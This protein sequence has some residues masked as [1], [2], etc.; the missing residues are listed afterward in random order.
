MKTQ[1]CCRSEIPCLSENT[2]L[3]K[4]QILRVCKKKKKKLKTKHPVSVVLLKC[5]SPTAE[6]SI[7]TTTRCRSIRLKSIMW[8]TDEM[9]M[10]V[11]VSSAWPVCAEETTHSSS[12]EGYV[13]ISNAAVDRKCQVAALFVLP[14]H[15]PLAEISLSDMSDVHHHCFRLSDRR[16]EK[17][18]KARIDWFQL[19]GEFPQ[20]LFE[21]HSHFSSLSNSSSWLIISDLI[22]L[23]D[24]FSSGP[25]TLIPFLIWKIVKEVKL[26]LVLVLQI[27]LDVKIWLRSISLGSKHF[28]LLFLGQSFHFWWWFIIYWGWLLNLSCSKRSLFSFTQWW[29]QNVRVCC[30]Q[31]VLLQ[32]PWPRVRVQRHKS[33]LFGGFL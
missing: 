7:R 14:A 20:Q 9:T 8:F 17:M 6:R 18:W 1:Q 25:D 5:V 4:M 21:I 2:Y 30:V 19:G 23:N 24:F 26:I 27:F 13:R 33:I 22:P 3:L 16:S 15:L 32:W 11:C 10:L 12:A 28:V 31:M 29:G